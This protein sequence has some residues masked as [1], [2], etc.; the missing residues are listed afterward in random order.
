MLEL[1]NCDGVEIIE[2][3]ILFAQ[4]GTPT[5]DACYAKVVANEE[6]NQFVASSEYG[7]ARAYIIYKDGTSIKVAYSK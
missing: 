5:V 2:K 4:S 3:G 7:N 6:T 1:V